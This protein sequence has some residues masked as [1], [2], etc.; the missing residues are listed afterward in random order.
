M[1]T[2][3]LIT[4]CLLMSASICFVAPLQAAPKPKPMPTAQERLP[5]G[6]PV[7]GK[8]GLVYSPYA[9]GKIMDVEGFKHG[10]IV[11]CPYTARKFRVP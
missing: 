4:A 11:M 2:V 10:T 5:V 1:K 7:P 6:V 3:K 9:R 8:P